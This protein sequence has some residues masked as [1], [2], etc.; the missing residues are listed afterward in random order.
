MNVLLIPQQAIFGSF[1]A[2]IA[3]VETEDGIV[4]RPL[5]LVNSDDFWTEVLSGLQ[6]GDRVVMQNSQSAS[7]PFSAFRQ[8]RGGNFSGGGGVIIQQRGG[9]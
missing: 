1:Q 9:R 3:R 8:L 2:P 5:I 6:E 4:E 7:D